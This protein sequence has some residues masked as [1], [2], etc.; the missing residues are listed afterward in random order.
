[1]YIYFNSQ[2]IIKIETT[3]MNKYIFILID[4]YELI[5]NFFIFVK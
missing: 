3:Y 1:M 4:R 5:Y 2:K